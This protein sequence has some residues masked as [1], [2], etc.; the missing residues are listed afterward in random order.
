LV[1]STW[2]RCEATTTV[3]GSRASR[4]LGIPIRM[5]RPARTRKALGFRPLLQAGGTHLSGI[6][7]VPRMPTG[8]RPLVVL[9]GRPAATRTADAWAGGVA[10][11][12]EGWFT[13]N[14][15]GRWRHAQIL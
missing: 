13:V 2:P 10:A 1:Q 7:R 8:S 9:A 4:S 5:S 11:S 12:V 15:G 3:G 6:E 14:H